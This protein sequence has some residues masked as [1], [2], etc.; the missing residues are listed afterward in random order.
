MIHRGTSD[1]T[2]ERGIMTNLLTRFI[3]EEEGQDLIEYALLGGL[4]TALVVASI[5]TI[6]TRVRTL[7]SNLQTAIAS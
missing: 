6:G 4:I 1:T 5:T 7:F 3:K 2:R